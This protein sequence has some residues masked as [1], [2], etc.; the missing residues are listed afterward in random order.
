MS[1]TNS[2]DDYVKSI[3]DMV[4]AVTHYKQ[5]ILQFLKQSPTIDANS[6]TIIE[7]IVNGSFGA[8]SQLYK[9]IELNTRMIDDLKNAINKLPN[10]T[11][12][13]EVKNAANQAVRGQEQDRQFKQSAKRYFEDMSKDIET[14]GDNL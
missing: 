10:R 1:S 14:S 2:D 9:H 3:S 6:K 5:G 4:D 13:N 7:H 12:F 11:E 8:I